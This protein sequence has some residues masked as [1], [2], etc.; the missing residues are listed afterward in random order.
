MT[1]FHFH[2]PVEQ[3]AGRDIVNHA[4]RSIWD[5]ETDA[6]W[7][8]REA[9][10]REHKRHCVGLDFNRAKV[11]LMVG[12]GLTLWSLTYW[13]VLYADRAWLLGVVVGLF[14]ALPFGWVAERTK[15]HQAGIY[16][17]RKRIEAIDEVLATRL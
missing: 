4:R 2:G 12:A 8:M 9:E 15:D 6:L 17:T 14:V 1:E 10:Y 3:V 16:R 5:L 11:C 7:A 13:N